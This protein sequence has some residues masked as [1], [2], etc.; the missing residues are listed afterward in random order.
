MRKYLIFLLFVSHIAVFSQEKFAWISDT[1]VGYDGADNELGEVVGL[2]NSIDE[3][4]FVV[5]TGDITEKGLNEEIET[6]S[7]VLNELN[8]PLF[9]IPGNHDTKWSESGCTK[10]AEIWDDNKFIHETN[11]TIF[12]GMNS[13]ITMKGGGGHFT[14]E[15]IS[16]L[17]DELSQIDTT[18]EIIFFS[19]HPL[20][21]DIDNWF[22]V[23]NLL[24]DHNIKA[25]LNG[26]GHNNKISE[27]NGIPAAMSRSTLSKGKKSYGFTLVEN[28]EDAIVFYE[29]EKDTLPNYWGTI[30]KNKPL[31]IKQIEIPQFKNNRASIDW[32]KDLNVSLSA[33]PIYWNDRVY[34]VDYSGLLSCID[35]SGTILWDYDMFGDVISKPAIFDGVIA[36]ATLQG[37]LVILNAK[38]GEQVQ[39]IGFDDA[40]IAPIVMFNYTGPQNLLMPKYT[41]STAAIIIT[42]SS[43]KVT[44][45]DLETLQEHWVNKDAKGMIE[46]EPT[47]IGNKLIYGSWDTYLYCLDT[48]NGTTIWKWKESDSFYYSPAVCKP[49]TDGKNLFITT[50]EKYTY[51]IDLRQGVTTWK[52]KVYNGW[53]SI[54]ISKDKRKLFVKS[55]EDHFH[56]VSAVT[57]NWVKDINMKFGIDTMPTTPIEW[58][59]NILFGAKN[60]NVYLIDK[61]GKY[62]SLIF[63]GSSRVQNVQQI[64]YNQF[65]A[66]NMDGQIVAVQNI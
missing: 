26:H 45:Y 24:R 5:A 40:I 60:G 8:K 28:S 6:A 39:T 13:G 50:P 59:K 9:I 11:S 41:K 17:K 51:A 15:D 16:W 32:Q 62:K 65:L 56:I 2:I 1:H 47:I 10:F 7:S 21:E 19:H 55:Y 27:F 38:T 54:G 20:N 61:D 58:E 31:N 42:T 49:V 48:K 57:T 3:I 43:G 37:D 22:E 53:E 36:T 18:L 33:E 64:G 25:V 35:S 44:C 14:P 4:A 12:I 34:T 30:H 52:K 63:L 66:S 29:V 46:V 23:S